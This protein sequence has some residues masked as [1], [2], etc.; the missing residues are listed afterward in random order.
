MDTDA[1]IAVSSGYGTAKRT[2]IWLKYLR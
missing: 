1:E 2:T